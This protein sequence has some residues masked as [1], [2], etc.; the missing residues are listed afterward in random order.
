M[1]ATVHRIERKGKCVYQAR[2][3]DLQ[4]GLDRSFYFELYMDAVRVKDL[5]LENGELPTIPNFDPKGPRHITKKRDTYIVHTFSGGEE[6]IYLKTKNLGEAIRY[7]N[8]LYGMEY[9]TCGICGRK[10]WDKFGE[11]VCNDC[12]VEHIEKEK[13]IRYTYPEKIEKEQRE[14]GRH[15]ADWQKEKTLQMAGRI[16][17]PIWAMREDQKEA[18]RKAFG[19]NWEKYYDQD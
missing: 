17:I 4:S 18:F 19:P 5:F 3:R 9:T 11:G 14:L 12:Y 7:R 10:F 1:S 2:L 6:T 15:Y 8:E 13:P 16:K